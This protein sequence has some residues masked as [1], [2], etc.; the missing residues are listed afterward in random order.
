M[1]RRGKYRDRDS[2]LPRPGRDGD[3]AVMANMCR[4]SL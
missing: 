2:W 3:W 1:S 4:V